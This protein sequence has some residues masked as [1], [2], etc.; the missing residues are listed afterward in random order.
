MLLI[1]NLPD[2]AQSSSLR[3]T[4]IVWVVAFIFHGIV[5]TQQF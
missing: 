3:E 1:K 4:D 5:G 2:F